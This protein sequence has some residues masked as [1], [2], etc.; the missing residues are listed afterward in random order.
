MAN[1][2]VQIATHD[3]LIKQQYEIHVSKLSS[4]AICNSANFQTRSKLHIV[5]IR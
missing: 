5:A 3:I 2:I 4:N 1:K